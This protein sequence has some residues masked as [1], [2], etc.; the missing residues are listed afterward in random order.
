MQ[1]DTHTHKKNHINIKRY[2]D[3]SLTSL[4]SAEE[5]EALTDRNHQQQ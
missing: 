3:V 1:N 5:E 4:R 2:A